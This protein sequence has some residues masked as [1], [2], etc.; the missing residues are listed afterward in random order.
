MNSYERFD[1]GFS[2]NIIS[3][4]DVKF[5][6]LVPFQRY[7]HGRYDWRL[8][9]IFLMDFKVPVSHKSLPPCRIPHYALKVTLW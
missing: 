2:D 7:L 5:T 6:N 1:V 3:I 4:L 8:W 9:G